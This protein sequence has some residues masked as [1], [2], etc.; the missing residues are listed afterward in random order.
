MAHSSGVH[1]GRPGA[2]SP[3]SRKKSKSDRCPALARPPVLPCIA[4]LRVGVIG[5]REVFCPAER[6]SELS[7]PAIIQGRSIER[8]LRGQLRNANWKATNPNKYRFH[9]GVIELAR[10]TKQKRKQSP[11]RKTTAKKKPAKRASRAKK[12]VIKRANVAVDDLTLKDINSLEQELQKAKAQVRDRERK[13]LRKKI[14]AL[15]EGTGFTVFDIY[16]VGSKKRG[17]S[18]SIARYANPADPSD[19]WTGR[20]RKPNWLLACL[21]KGRKL[22]DY[23]I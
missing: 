3:I 7:L 18:I 11:K 21:K 14:D 8:Q 12:A 4:A 22:E 23:A 19:T 1:V 16:G 10:K 2:G 13:A 9:L 6:A 15:L 20:G 5:K 17:K